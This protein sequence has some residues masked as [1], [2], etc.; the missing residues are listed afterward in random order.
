MAT[1][2]EGAPSQCDDSLRGL[3]AEMTGLSDRRGKTPVV[4]V[5]RGIV[6]EDVFFQHLTESLLEI[7]GRDVRWEILHSSLTWFGKG[8]VQR[9]RIRQLQRIVQRLEST[10]SDRPPRASRIEVQTCVVFSHPA[11]PLRPLVVGIA[12]WEDTL[13]PWTHELRLTNLPRTP[14]DIQLVAA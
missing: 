14:R 12:D 2:T 10:S 5:D 1:P 4:M 8:W 7:A 9:E 13:P 6:L 3:A 11:G